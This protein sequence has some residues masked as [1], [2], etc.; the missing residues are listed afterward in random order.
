MTTK[1]DYK[2]ARYYSDSLGLKWQED[3]VPEVDKEFTKIDLTQTQVDGVMWMWCWRMK[4]LSTASNY[5]FWQRVKIAAHFL[6]GK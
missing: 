2:T 4:H 5:K 1:Y 6:R 3:W